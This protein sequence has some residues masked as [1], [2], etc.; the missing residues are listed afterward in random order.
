MAQTQNNKIAEEGPP[1]VP[2]WMVTFCDCMTLLLCFFVLM[3]TFSS[4]DDGAL[5]K[6]GAGLSGRPHK[7]VFGD[8]RTV[9]DSMVP[10][11]DRPIDYTEEGSE[12]L[13][14]QEQKKVENP[15]K[16]TQLFNTDAYRD[17]NTV[18]IPSSKL[19]H[20]KG[21]GMKPA[22]RGLLKVI[23]SF[24]RRMPC[25]IIIGEINAE[26]G[27][28]STDRAWAVM[29]YFT[30]TEA[31]DSDRFSISAGD[32]TLRSNSGGKPM[33]EITMLARGIYR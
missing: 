9:R 8:R 30:E 20:A 14:E 21:S 1:A 33:M 19:F 5:S 29:R 2:A 10:H 12:R 24:M 13:T 25:Q 7:S 3:L 17:R 18:L 28:T 6:L 16:S 32:A 11:K 31:L 22:G 4:F 23:A 15:R 26:R 27:G